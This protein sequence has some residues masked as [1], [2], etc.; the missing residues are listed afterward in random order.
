MRGQ[1][2][3]SGVGPKESTVRRARLPPWTFLS[4]HAHVLLLTAAEPE[5]C[6]RDVA[7]RIGITE[8]AVQRIVAD[9][10]A[11]RYLERERV[12]RRNRYRVHAEVRMRHPIVA[13]NEIGEM[14]RLLQR[15]G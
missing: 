6:L 15:G 2:R 14:L 9:L 11:S 7:A 8:R 10:V 13:H 5:V 4:N 3:E 1:P 12:G